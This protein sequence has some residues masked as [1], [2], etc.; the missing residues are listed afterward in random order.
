MIRLVYGFERILN[1]DQV[2][3]GKNTIIH[4]VIQSPSKSDNRFIHRRK[5]S[6]SREKNISNKGTVQMRSCQ[7]ARSLCSMF[8]DQYG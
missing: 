6:S 7:G 5:R 3:L 8:C 2:I 1:L 4:S